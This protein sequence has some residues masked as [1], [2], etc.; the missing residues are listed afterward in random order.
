MAMSVTDQPRHQIVTRG[1]GDRVLAS[2]I[3]LGDG[4]HVGL[5]ETGAE[6]LE[7]IGQSGVAMGLVAGDD[8]GALAVFHGLPRSLQNGGNLDR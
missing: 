1:A 2:G 3:D 7:K 6:V 8:A 5:V 4:D